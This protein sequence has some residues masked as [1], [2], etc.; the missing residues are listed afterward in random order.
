[1]GNLLIRRAHVRDGEPVQDIL[2]EDG[3]ITR[4]AANIS[5]PEGSSVAVVDAHD[6]V[7]LPGLIESH[8]HPD[9]ALLEAKKPNVSGTLAEA[10][11]NTGE[12]KANF[13]VE[14]VAARAKTVMQW[15]SARGTTIMRA[16]PDVDPISKLVGVTG[17]LQLKESFRDIMDL[18]IVAFPQ[19]G[20]I[21]SP[22][23]YELMV[24]AMQ[25][26]CTVIGGCPYNEATMEETVR[27]LEIVFEL[28]ERFGAP[29]DMHV[30][31]TDHID[32]QR[33]MTTE[34]IC[35]MTEARGMQGRVSLGHV[36]TLG[37]IEPDHP[38][39]DKIAKAGI[40]IVTLPPTD[41]YLN[42]RGD[43]HNIR[44]G[45][46]PVNT[47]LQHGIN[48]VYSSNNVRNAFTPL[49]NADLI[50][51]GYLLAEVNHIGSAQFAAVLDMVTV[52]AAKA[53][54]LSKEY[55]LRVGARGDAVI[56]SSNRVSDVIADQPCARTVIKNGLVVSETKV[57]TESR[58]L[59]S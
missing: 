9:K 20:I 41:L 52:N 1:M 44:R 30:D 29:I 22:G 54:G 28:A 23:T 37:S 18:E 38:V 17:L 8:I 57:S 42:G 49:G 12:L 16:H 50:L 53:L 19:E 24:E 26:G 6:H 43:T 14:D 51:G 32:D 59:I 48:V 31:F 47:M 2:I 4:I 34:I 36:T 56:V 46:A 35:E 3:T 10:I 33:Y 55:G 13:T 40:S 27:H 11:R 25:L 15:A 21:K 58:A 5:S 39:F 7:V 45:I